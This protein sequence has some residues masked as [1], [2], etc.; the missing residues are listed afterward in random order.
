METNYLQKPTT[1]GSYKA[2]P[3]KL[4]KDGESAHNAN[5]PWQ[6][7]RIH[8]WPA[9]LHTHFLLCKLFTHDRASES[10]PTQ[11]SQ[12]LP[13]TGTQFERYLSSWFQITKNDGKIP[14]DTHC[15]SITPI[16]NDKNSTLKI[17]PRD[18]LTN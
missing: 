5:S 15:T 3:L 2:R 1:L 13:P 17:H 11:K 14:V 16:K 7:L 10:F 8:T 4:S 18:N 6:G 9:C 12:W